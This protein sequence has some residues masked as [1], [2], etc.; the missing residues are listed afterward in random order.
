MRKIVWLIIQLCLITSYAMAVDYD[1]D[2]VNDDPYR[3]NFIGYE[4]QNLYFYIDLQSADRF[5][6]ITLDNDSQPY[7]FTT[8][9]GYTM[10]ND[11]D[12]ILQ[13][14][15]MARMRVVVHPERLTPGLQQDLASGALKLVM[16]KS[17][18]DTIGDVSDPITIMDNS[19]IALDVTID[20]LTPE[21]ENLA[22][23]LNL[24]N[25]SS[26]SN[27]YIQSSD[28]S[29]FLPTDDRPFGHITG[30]NTYSTHNDLSIISG[31]PLI[32]DGWAFDD[33]DG[34]AV[35]MYY[36]RPSDPTDVQAQA[37]VSRQFNMINLELPYWGQVYPSGF[38]VEWDNEDLRGYYDLRIE[39]NDGSHT[40]SLPTQK[41]FWN[42]PPDGGLL[43]PIHNEDIT[44]PEILVSGIAYDLDVD[45]DINA[46]LSAVEVYVDSSSNLIG[47]IPNTAPDNDTME[48][49]FIWDTVYDQSEGEH[50]I[51]AIAYD[52]FG[53]S[54]QFGTRTITIYKTSPV[55]IS[56]VPRL[57]PWRANTVVSI[58]GANLSSVSDVH[59]GSTA[60]SIISA[61]QTDTLMQ[62]QLPQI[63]DPASQYV[64]V[65]IGNT[66]NGHTKQDGYRFVPAEL[67]LNT[68]TDVISDMEFNN[69]TG[70]LYLLNQSTRQ[71]DIYEPLPGDGLVYGATDSFAIRSTAV[72]SKIDLSKEQTILYALYD[73]LS[74][75]EIYDLQTGGTLIDAVALEDNDGDPVNPVS[76]AYLMY[77]I[78]LIGSTTPNACLL[79]AQLDTSGASYDISQLPIGLQ[80]EDIEVVPSS[81]KATAYIVA[82][83]TDTD[84]FDVFLYEART[85][86]LTPLAVTIPLATGQ[87][88]EVSVAP[89]Y[90]GSEFLVYTSTDIA[91]FDHTGSLLDSAVYGADYVTFDNT[92]AMLYT[93]NSGDSFFT[94]K[95][96]SDLSES[97]S[98]IHFPNAQFASG[99]PV[100]DWI[101]DKLFALTPQGIA[102]VKIGDIYPQ[103]SINPMFV[104]SDDTIELVAQ[105]AGHVPEN[106]E[107]YVND[108]LQS[109]KT[110]VQ[111]D[112]DTHTFSM[113]VTLDDD[114]SGKLVARL[115]GY[116]SKAENLYLLSSLF[117]KV[118][119]MSGL[120]T[121]Q[122]GGLFY[123]DSRSDLYVFDAW[124]ATG[125][126]IAR[127]HI[128][129]DSQGV[130]SAQRLAVPSEIQVPYPV[131]MSRANDYILVISRSMKS[132]YWFD[133]E[134]F[135]A[136][137]SATVLS[138]M[139]SP[140]ISLSGVAGYSPK[141][142]IGVNYAYVWNQ[143]SSGGPDVFQINLDTQ[144]VARCN[145]IS[146]RTSDVII[147]YADDP[148]DDRAYAV[149][150]TTPGRQSDF[151]TI[152]D[153][154]QPATQIIALSTIDLGSYSGAYQLALND[155]A[156]FSTLRTVKGVSLI[157]P[158]HSGADN[159]VTLNI[160]EGSAI[161]PQFITTNNDFLAF[162]GVQAG[163]SYALSFIDVNIWNDYPADAPF[164]VTATYAPASSTLYDI[165]MIQNKLFTVID[166]EIYIID[167]LDTQE[168]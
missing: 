76:M 89:N 14:L 149:S 117:D 156:L 16:L 152:F 37:A 31:D 157:M 120:E 162:D 115:N 107:V 59:F 143:L 153:P 97:I 35:T 112:N 15:E 55:I 6:S 163:N 135:D 109:G 73:N 154:T 96:P 30:L 127:F 132:C 33:N 119:D 79:M 78:V 56:I 111:S 158:D 75:L 101:G 102:A 83:D 24:Y 166:N 47:T 26:G 29:L 99:E 32:L 82:K 52:S 43:T 57:G 7:T 22:F 137:S 42:K 131:G 161:Q 34:M 49:Q 138:A 19:E 65:T 116:T 71:V 140:Y 164:D 126:T 70:Q 118:A 51:Y 92:R 81:N 74:I 39:L 90:N 86:L 168:D 36:K 72:P 114:T 13:P 150:Y 129:V 54:T 160:L 155:E 144:A 105:N 108:Q 68:I 110:L 1:N 148:A 44:D 63:S 11:N 9:D 125:T 85:M 61:S 100:L 98:Y 167:L 106:I 21:M 69:M 147:D 122:P 142:D 41:V 141:V 133:V 145:F 151:V 94:L 128:E 50:T 45:V 53:L 62:V 91:L 104:K 66:A 77:D 17:P 10:S 20:R 4:S 23:T 12:G 130:V 58:T 134:T 95:N 40:V 60:A 146:P 25:T 113:P 18:P 124:K 8:S 87:V 88:G 46:Y 103:L 3:P 93:F 27:V 159:H 139:V 2:G 67:G 38:T 28:T 165:Q 5:Y 64:D 80:Y 136:T 48:F 84:T 123:D 121:F